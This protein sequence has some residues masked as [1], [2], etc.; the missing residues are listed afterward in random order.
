VKYADYAIIDLD[1][2]PRARFA[3]VVEVAHVVKDVLDELGLHAVPKTSGASGVHIVLPLG[4]GV[5]N[6]GARI[7]AELVARKVAESQPKIATV[8]RWVKARPSGTVYVDF[9]QNIRGKTV[10]GVYSVR[11]Q[12]VPSVSTPLEWNELVEDLD[13]ASFTIDTL[14]QRVSAVG[15]LWA[16]GMK[17]PN[18]LDGILGRG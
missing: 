9:L 15:D 7:V 16:K 4:P 11:A 6:D 3:R 17:T 5:P 12:P 14:P 8:E 1:P 13:P 2:G 18:S 10:A